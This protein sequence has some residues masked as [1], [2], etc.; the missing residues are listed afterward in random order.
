[1]ENFNHTSPAELFVGSVGGRSRRG[2]GYYRFNTGDEALSFVRD[3]FKGDLLASVVMQIDDE[4]FN[5]DQIRSH[6][7]R[8]EAVA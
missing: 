8:E 3:H 6:L 5:A 1:M 4:R 2:L 7:N